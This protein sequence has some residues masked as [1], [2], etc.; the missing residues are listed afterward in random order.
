MRLDE[1][2]SPAA[3]KPSKEALRRLARVAGNGEMMAHAVRQL[4]KG[5]AA[6]ELEGWL[7]LQELR[8]EDGVEIR[9]GMIG[10]GGIVAAVPSGPAPRF[11]HFAEAE[12]QADALAA[13]LDVDRQQVLGVVVLTDSDDAPTAHFYDKTSA[14]VVGD[15]QLAT[16]LS[17]MPVVFEPLLLAELRDAIF[18][19]A[20][21]AAETRPTRLP[22]RP[23]WG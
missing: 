4:E 15:R 5:R 23:L 20:V 17:C 7:L 3:T 9:H 6:I 12:H 13:L 16:W 22:N 10:P 1:E 8:L 19:C 11:E 21:L 14:I 2:H 18:T